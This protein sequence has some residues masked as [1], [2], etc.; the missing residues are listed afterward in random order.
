MF[1]RLDDTDT[2]PGDGSADG[3]TYFRA[4]AEDREGQ[5][6]VEE[7]GREGISGLV[8]L[9]LFRDVPGVGWHRDF[10][11]W[12]YCWAGVRDGRDIVL[13]KVACMKLRGF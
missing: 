2:L 8:V 9:W 11:C 3:D 6:W 12:Q 1:V 7:R 4:D 5:I 10:A 13:G